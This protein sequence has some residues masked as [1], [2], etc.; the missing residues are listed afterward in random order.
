M[1]RGVQFVHE[2]FKKMLE[3]LDRPEYNHLKSKAMFEW[4]SFNKLTRTGDV[5]HFFLKYADGNHKNAAVFKFLENY[6]IL[7]S[8][9][10]S[11]YLMEN[12]SDEIEGEF[13]IDKLVVN[14]IYNNNDLFMLFKDFMSGIRSNREE[15]IIGCVTSHE[16]IYEDEWIDERTIL[17]TGEG[18]KGNQTPNSSGNKDLIMAANDKSWRVFLFEKIKPNKYY[19]RGEVDVDPLIKQKQN[20]LD[21][22][23]NPRS[24]IQFTMTLK[25]ISEDITYTEEDTLIIEN[26]KKKLIEKLKPEIIHR[27]AKNKE[28]DLKVSYVNVKQYNRDQAVSRDTKNRAN[29]IC[30]L[31]HQKAPFETKDGPYLESHHLIW[32]ANGGPDVIYNTVALCPNCHRRL[33]ALNDKKDIKKLQD[34]ISKYL[35]DDNDREN[36]LRFEKLFNIKVDIK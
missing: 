10:I 27:L 33:H 22:D 17:Y 9:K 1:D 34:A 4:N 8:E 18:K 23:Y 16:G 25:K 29:G 35:L 15:K 28:E 12:Y 3:L 32:I 14:D 31:C 2:N 30:D 11:D 20:V 19:Y 13:G 6:G 36:I 5:Y 24:V 7:S 21:E 26:N